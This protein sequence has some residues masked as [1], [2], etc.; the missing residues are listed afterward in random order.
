MIS[1]SFVGYFASEEQTLDTISRVYKLNDYLIDTHTAVA[2]SALEQYR[3]ETADTAKTVVAST[4]SPFKFAGS[5]YSAIF[6]ENDP[7]E[8]DTL[9]DLSVT[10]GVKIPHPLSDL[11]KKQVNF[12]KSIAKENML[13]E[14]LDFVKK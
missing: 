7:D 8:F 1:E 9:R 13:E 10:T 2:F 14:I 11:S 3:A 4:A 6:G 5:V 12:A